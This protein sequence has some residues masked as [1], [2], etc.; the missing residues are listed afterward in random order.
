VNAPFEIAFDNAE[1]EF[2]PNAVDA[3]VSIVVKNN[4]VT[5]IEIT[6]VGQLSTMVVCLPFPVTVKGGDTTLL[7]ILIKPQA[8]DVHSILNAAVGFKY[9]DQTLILTATAQG[10][11]KGA[12]QIATQHLV[13]KLGGKPLEQGVAVR[14]P[15]GEQLRGVRLVGRDG[16]FFARIDMIQS[17]VF[18]TPSDTSKPCSASIWL[19]TEPS[20]NPRLQVPIEAAV[21]AKSN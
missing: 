7:K 10:R 13:W 21:E 9:R 15:S 16:A 8:L 1:Y 11:L 20:L 14:F 6:H 17:K 19:V 4:T 2:D 18:V 3:L 5:P 12:P